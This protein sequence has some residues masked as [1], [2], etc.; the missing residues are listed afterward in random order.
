MRKKQVLDQLAALRQK[1]GDELK[2]LTLA[3]SQGTEVKPEEVTA[4][5]QIE[6]DIKK[7]ESELKAIEDL[8]QRAKA[9]VAAEAPRQPAQVH[10]NAEDRPFNGLGE[11]LQ[12]VA[13]SMTP[14][15]SMDPRLRRFAPT[16][17]G[18]TV[19]S[20][21]GFRVGADMAELMYNR[22]FE[23]A[24]VASRCTRRQ[25]S[26]PAG[27]LVIPYIDETSRANGSR[28]GG[29]RVYRRAEADTVTAAKAKYGRL[30]IEADSMM[31]IMYAT[32]ELLADVTALSAE[33]TQQ[34]GDEFG[35]KLDDEIING[36][37][38]GQ[39]EGILN[40]GAL[41]SVSKETGQAAATLEYE[42]LV[43]MHCRMPVRNRAS[44]VW[45]IN[46]D[47]EPQLM[48]LVQV[49]GTGGVPVYLPP[50]GASAEPYGR[51]FGRPVI[52]I[53]QCATLGTVGDILFADMSQYLLVEKGGLQA[54][55][56]MH[57]RFLYNEMTFRWTARIN[58]KPRWRSAITPFKGTSTVS[59][60]I[61][62]A[63]RA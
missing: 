61:A 28:Y 46:Q 52:P 2:R 25:L 34:F 29:V 48:T 12:S 4:L 36:N 26:N 15:N 10:N 19:P 5:D 11:F 53:E 49:I 3:A 56:S 45:F 27:K 58:G 62:L 37:G 57:V 59:P 8:E 24:N 1:H 43:K 50:G 14:G 9:N 22:G 20:D 47:L 21:G 63:T 6:T 23:S 35:F 44:A 7:F 38:V 30:E 54:D 42:N 17:A 18:E 32:E 41:I 13:F 33:A 55:Q 31:G 40:A 39:C 51:I 60:F 16:G